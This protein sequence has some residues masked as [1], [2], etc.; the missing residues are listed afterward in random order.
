M[1][2]ILHLT[3]KREYF[4]QIAKKQK[5]VEYRKRKALLA[6]TIGRAKV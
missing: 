3:S 6:E 1:P 4:A 5:H 2:E